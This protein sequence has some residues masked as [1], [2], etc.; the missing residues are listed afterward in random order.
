M[1]CEDSLEQKRTERKLMTTDKNKTKI[2]IIII[3]III[4]DNTGLQLT[5]ISL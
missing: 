2:I 1:I 3:I 4:S 5:L